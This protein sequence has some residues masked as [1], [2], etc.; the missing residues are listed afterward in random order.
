MVRQQLVRSVVAVAIVVTGTAALSAPAA[1]VPPEIFIRYEENAQA[2]WV[3]EEECADGSLAELFVA[4]IAGLEFE[5]PELADVNEFGLLLVQGSRCD[6]SFVFER[7]SGT[8]DYTGSLTLRRARVSGTIALD[9]GGVASLEVQWTGTGRVE[10][11]VNRTERPGF[12]GIFR[13]R[14]REAEATGTVTLDGAPLVSGPS[15]SADIETLEDFNVT[16]SPP[17]G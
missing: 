2:N 3:I 17:D 12:L 5:S 1:A 15:D 10:T 9:D 4:V 13:N 14:Q 11:T 8:V 7:G 16:F 6:G